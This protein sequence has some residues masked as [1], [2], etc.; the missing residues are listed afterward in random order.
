MSA[1]SHLFLTKSLSPD[2]LVDLCDIALFFSYMTFP[3]FDKKAKTL[4]MTSMFRAKIPRYHLNSANSWNLPHSNLYNGRTRYPLCQMRSGTQLRSDLRAA[5]PQA[6]T[7]R[8]LSLE[9][10]PSYS[11]SSQPFL[12]VTAM[13]PDSTENVKGAARKIT[14]CPIC[15]TFRPARPS[16][17][18]QGHRSAGTRPRSAA[19]S[20]RW[21]MD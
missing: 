2:S 15:F 14:H 12:D 9:A 5:A 21:R 19:A 8:L 20:Q 13:I 1:V 16:A 18:P 6:H 17:Y 10:H 7:S 4:N 3:F 11:S